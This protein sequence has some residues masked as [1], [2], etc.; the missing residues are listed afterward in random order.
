ML[1]KKPKLEIEPSVLIAKNTW[2]FDTKVHV[3]PK[4][5]VYATREPLHIILGIYIIGFDIGQSGRI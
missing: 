1:K 4:W 3:V 2:T 5:Y